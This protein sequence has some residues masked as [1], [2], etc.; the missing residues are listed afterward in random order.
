MFSSLILS[1]KL[2]RKFRNDLDFYLSKRKKHARTVFDRPFISLRRHKEILTFILGKWK[3]VEDKQEYK[4]VFPKLIHSMRRR[5]DYLFFNAKLL[6][7]KW[8][9]IL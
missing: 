6:L 3:K 4:I 1:E 9:M 2:K 7:M 5:Y 8:P